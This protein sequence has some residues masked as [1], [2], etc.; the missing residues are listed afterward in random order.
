M[1]QPTRPGEIRKVVVSDFHL[2][3]G[4]RTGEL[5]PWENFFYDEEFAD[6]LLFY[7]SDE[8]E[9]RDVELIINGD[10]FDLLQVRYDGGFPVHITESIAVAKL[11]A[12]LD[13]HPVVLNAMRRFVERPRKRIT[14]L[15]GNHDFELVFPACHRLFRERVCG[16]EEDPRMHFVLERPYY[17]FD[18]V[19]VHHGM[20]F[21]AMN[22]YRWDDKF[23]REGV[24][25]PVLRQPFGSYFV[26]EVLNAMKEKRPYVDRVQPFALYLAGAVLFDTAVALRLMSLAARA[27]WRYR[28]RP[29]LAR[30]RLNPVTLSEFLETFWEYSAFPNFERKVHKMMRRNPRIHTVIMGHTHLRKVRRFAHNRT[31]INTGTWTDLI[32]LEISNLGVNRELTYATVEY[33]P[34]RPPLARLRAWKGYTQLWREIHY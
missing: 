23:I 30:P 5:N 12:A 28:L 33:F 13:G 26:L 24:P 27:F 21:E 8:Y 22:R 9:E 31:Y 1:V 10:F 14:V 11:A 19:Q 2:G 15:P 4:R 25:Q 20:Q 16:A 7:S 17:E 6:L 34:D 29:L 32:S 18:G 3:A